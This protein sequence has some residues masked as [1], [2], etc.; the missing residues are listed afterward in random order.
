M[1]KLM[2]YGAAGYTGGMAAE[3]AASAGLDLVLAGR[4]KDRS[5]IETFVHVTEG[6]FPTGNVQAL[7]A[8]PSI[9]ERAANRYHAAVEVTGADGTVARSGLDTVNGY[10]FTSMAA[11]EAARRVLAGEVRPGFQTP[12]GLFGYG[13]AETIADTRITDMMLSAANRAAHHF[14]VRA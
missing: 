3:H 7:P 2:I 12:A 10:T 5:H 9:E 14:P 1:R 4:E 8:G 6:A 11:A 13:F